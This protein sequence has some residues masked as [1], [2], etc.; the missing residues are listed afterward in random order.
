MKVNLVIEFGYSLALAK[1][2]KRK[3]KRERWESVN[4][5]TAI[6]NNENNLVYLT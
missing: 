6:L 3:E 2:N 1:Q 5:D 4:S